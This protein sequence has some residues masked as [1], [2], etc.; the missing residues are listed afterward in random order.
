M[1]EVGRESLSLSR[2]GSTLARPDFLTELS[3]LPYCV[4][5]LRFVED[6]SQG[7]TDVLIG[8]RW[9]SE[10]AVLERGSRDV[11]GVHALNGGGWSQGR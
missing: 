1:A 9:R 4:K 11:T 5:A 2:A 6:E 8:R 7:D 10:D 3:L